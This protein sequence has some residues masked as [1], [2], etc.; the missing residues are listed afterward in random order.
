[1]VFTVILGSTP[2]RGKSQQRQTTRENR[3]F[4]FRQQ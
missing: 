3:I 4:V 2:F 1:M